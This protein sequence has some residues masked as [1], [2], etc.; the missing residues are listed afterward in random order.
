[1]QR[2]TLVL[3][4]SH[5]PIIIIILY[6]F[7]ARTA[8]ERYYV[9]ETMRGRAPGRITNIDNDNDNNIVFVTCH[10]DC[11]LPPIPWSLVN[12]TMNLRVMNESS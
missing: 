5:R 6:C 9:M 12:T 11:H 8:I 10:T 7:T 2:E 1:M 3:L 4:G